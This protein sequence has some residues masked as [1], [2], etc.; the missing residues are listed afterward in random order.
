MRSRLSSL[1]TGPALYD[2]ACSTK[3]SRNSSYTSSKTTIRLAAAQR[4]PAL[5]KD[6]ASAHSTA[7]SRSASSQTTR[8]FLPPSSRQTLARRRP[9]C[10]LIQRPVAAEPVK[11]TKSTSD[12]S[13]S[14]GPTSPPSPWTTLTTPGG[15][16]SLQS[17]PKSAAERGVC[18]D[19]FSTVAFP[20]RTAGKTFQ[21]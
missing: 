18:S 16:S 10:S 2:A 4:C 1:I 5:E 13:T 20:H 7:R 12:D 9:A 3:R 8:A 6:D 15:S 14:G 17:S 21:A 11:L 19:G